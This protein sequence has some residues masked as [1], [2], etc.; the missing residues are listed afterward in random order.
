M[1]DAAPLELGYT[2]IQDYKYA[3]PLAL[4][5]FQTGSE[6]YA[7]ASNQLSARTNRTPN[8]PAVSFPPVA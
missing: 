2:I 3:A 6:N 8:T 1:G 7:C 5:L 4:Y